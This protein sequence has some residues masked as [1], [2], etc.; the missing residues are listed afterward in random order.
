M[1]F[2]IQKNINFS[3]QIKGKAIISSNPKGQVHHSNGL[4]FRAILIFGI[5]KRENGLQNMSIFFKM[6]QNHH[7]WFILQEF[8]VLLIKIMHKIKRIKIKRSKK[9]V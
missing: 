9:K 7:R 2:F 5:K 3:R 1:N 4:A 8:H 6:K